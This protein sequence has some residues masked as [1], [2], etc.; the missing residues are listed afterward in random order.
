MAPTVAAWQ[1]K[2]FLGRSSTKITLH[3]FNP[4]QTL[5]FPLARVRHCHRIVQGGEP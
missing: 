4:D 2:Q 1:M 3:Q 5:E